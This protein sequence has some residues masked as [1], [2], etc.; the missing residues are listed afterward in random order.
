MS[1]ITIILIIVVAFLA[2]ME[3]ILD[4]F[5]VGQTSVLLLHQMLHWLQSLLQLL[6][7]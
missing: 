1:A 4:E 3:G 6:W 2:G 7:Y 5:E